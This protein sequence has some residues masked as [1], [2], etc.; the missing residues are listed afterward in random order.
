VKKDLNILREIREQ[1]AVIEKDFANFNISDP[2]IYAAWMSQT[3]YYVRHSTRLLALAGSHMDFSQDKIR[4]RFFQHISEE[5]GHEQLAERDVKLV[6][7]DTAAF[8]ELPETQNLYQ[9]QYFWIQHIHPLSLL[10]YIFALESIAVEFGPMLYDKAAKAHGEKACAFLKLHSSEDPDHLEKAKQQYESL[11]DELK[12]MVI[13]N[14]HQSFANYQA[15]LT[16]SVALA[17][18]FKNAA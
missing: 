5:S 3:F 16:S 15:L 14:M 13:E 2:L 7:H 8:A 18:R 9:V 10:G 17:R 6:G 1:F 12:E 11:S 4:R